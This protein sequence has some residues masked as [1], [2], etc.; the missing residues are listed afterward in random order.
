MILDGQQ[1]KVKAEAEAFLLGATKKAN[2][3][4]D[5]KGAKGEGG[6]VISTHFFKPDMTE[7]VSFIPDFIE[8]EWNTHSVHDNRIWSEDLIN[9]LEDWEEI[10]KESLQGKIKRAELEA[11]YSQIMPAKIGCTVELFS[12]DELRDKFRENEHGE[13][14]FNSVDCSMEELEKIY[15]Q[16]VEHEIYWTDEDG[17]FKVK[18]FYLTLS[19]ETI[20][21]NKGV[22]KGEVSIKKRCAEQEYNITPS[23][24][25]NIK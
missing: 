3:Y 17:D 21:E 13:V 22:T 12:L 16:G 19:S 8:S 4:Y 14:V 18:G 2:E 25:L 7:V 5:K 9:T 20:K 23:S 1:K 24:S 6:G 10:N 11:E 15:E